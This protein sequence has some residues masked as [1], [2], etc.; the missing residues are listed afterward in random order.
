MI[1]L[2]GIAV[3]GYVL[4]HNIY[5]VPPSPFDLFPYLVGAWLV[6]GALVIVFVPGLRDRVA[7][8]IAASEA[9]QGEGGV[10]QPLRRARV[11]IRAWS[12][13][14]ARWQ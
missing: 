13:E 9:A 4:Y 8:G 2:A 6:I 3:A 10:T 12:A 5:P 7:V 14:R 1:P 11:P